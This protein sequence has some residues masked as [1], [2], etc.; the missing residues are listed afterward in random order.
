[1]PDKTHNST[2]RSII[3]R[4]DNAPDRPR[5]EISAGGIV[6]KKTA[7]GI[8]FA[9]LKDS[10]GK[11][12][13]PKGH[14]KRGEHYVDAAKREVMEEMG[15]ANMKLVKPLGS[16]DIWFRDRFVFKGRLIHKY[17]HYFLFEVRDN[18]RLQKPEIDTGGE[19]IQAV[20]WVPA[21]E[22]LKRS[23]YKDMRPIIDRAFHRLGLEYRKKKINPRKP[24]L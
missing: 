9:M 14:V 2:R 21:E 4:T 10:Y 1:M 13:F 16:I 6:F 3:S 22:V 15:I 8:F 12:T 5:I 17:I 7:R 19:R 11:W 20:A 24:N 23:N 18:I